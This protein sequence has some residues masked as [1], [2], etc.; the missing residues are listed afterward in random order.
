M[1]TTQ[2]TVAFMAVSMSSTVIIRP[3]PLTTATMRPV[4]SGSAATAPRRMKACSA[5]VPGRRS[6]YSAHSGW[7]KRA[8]RS[9]SIATLPT[10]TVPSVRASTGSIATHSASDKATA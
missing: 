5:A 1:S 8:M 9:N 4:G 3:A 2:R 7:R 10:A 6:P